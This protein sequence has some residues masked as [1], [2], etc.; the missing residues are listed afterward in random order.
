[1]V[2]FSDKSPYSNHRWP[3]VSPTTAITFLA[4]L[5][6]SFK[7]GPHRSGAMSRISRKKMLINGA[8]LN[9]RGS[10][11]FRCSPSYRLRRSQLWQIG[12]IKHSL[13]IKAR[14]QF[15]KNLSQWAVSIFFYSHW[16]TSTWIG[17]RMLETCECR[18]HRAARA[19]NFN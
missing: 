5:I 12:W 3:E 16:T 8:T 7:I 10:K 18:R 6:S 17:V 9:H 13:D 2:L 15:V 11:A 19:K 14:A 1:M 4:L